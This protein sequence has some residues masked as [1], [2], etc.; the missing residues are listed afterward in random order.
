[1]LQTLSEYND[2]LVVVVILL[3]LSFEHTPEQGVHC[4]PEAVHVKQLV[5]QLFSEQTEIS[6]ICV[7]TK[8]IAIK[9]R[10]QRILLNRLFIPPTF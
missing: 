9:N 3:G 7:C 1:M 10:K 4:P 6:I 2:K 8:G 5:V